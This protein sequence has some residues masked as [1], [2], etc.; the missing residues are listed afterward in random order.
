[1]RRK[2]WESEYEDQRFR[3][4]QSGARVVPE[5]R[6]YRH[7]VTDS[8]VFIPEEV[9]RQVGIDRKIGSYLRWAEYDSIFLFIMGFIKEQRIGVINHSFQYD[10]LMITFRNQTMASAFRLL[11]PY[12]TKVPEK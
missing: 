8:T 6:T 10:G 4:L 2:P 12:P 11:F 7:P 1:M 3:T 5:D 9:L